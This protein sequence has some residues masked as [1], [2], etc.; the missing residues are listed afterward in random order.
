MT[1][2]AVN[3]VADAR[4]VASANAPGGTLG[5]AGITI[6]LPTA[7]VSGHTTARL[8]GAITGSGSVLVHALAEN[9][10]RAD[11]DILQ[12]AI[13]GISGA[14]A[15]AEVTAT[16]TSRRSSTPARRSRAPATSRSRPTCR[17]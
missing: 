12:V 4:N 15:K 9:R 16:P 2:G 13:G 8:D 17:A 1:G 14:Y 10:A 7:T 5:L 6:M 3:V 11:V